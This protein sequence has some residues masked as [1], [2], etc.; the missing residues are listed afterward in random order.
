MIARGRGVLNKNAKLT[1]AQVADIKGLLAQGYTCGH[2]SDLYS[3]NR[4]TISDI[5]LGKTWNTVEPAP[6]PIL[7]T[8]KMK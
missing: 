7:P 1:E 4:H 2:L 3:V 8:S 5:K 6:N